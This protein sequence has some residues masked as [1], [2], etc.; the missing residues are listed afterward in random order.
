VKGK[1]RTLIKAIPPSR[2]NTI[3]YRERIVWDKKT[4]VDLVF[5]SSLLEE[6]SE[7]KA[8]DAEYYDEND[9]WGASGST[10]VTRI[11]DVVGTYDEWWLAQQKENREAVAS[12]VM[13]RVFLSFEGEKV[14]KI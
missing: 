13:P 9:G 10:T 6:G 11:E 8:K 2:I 3:L 12:S 5:G 4:K 1:E 14:M 7:E